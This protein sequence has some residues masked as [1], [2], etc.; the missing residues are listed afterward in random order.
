MLPPAL[1]R[2]EASYVRVEREAHA[3][4][5]R[6]IWFLRPQMP[7]ARH[8]AWVF[9][10]VVVPP[11]A[12]LNFTPRHA[13]LRPASGNKRWISEIEWWISENEW[14]I[15]CAPLIDS[16]LKKDPASCPAGLSAIQ[17]ELIE[18]MPRRACARPLPVLRIQQHEQLSPLPSMPRMFDAAS[19]SH[20]R[21]A[22][23]PSVL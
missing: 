5:R 3:A 6:H 22:A 17:A 14:W 16:S 1:R 4:C 8:H 15:N 23:A 9:M 7:P 21:P 2:L 19:S 18:T 11:L 10:I 12:P 13:E 20:R